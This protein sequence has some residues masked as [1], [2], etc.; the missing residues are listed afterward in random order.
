MSQ[1]SCNF[2]SSEPVL[3]MIQQIIHEVDDGMGQLTALGL[4][5][6]GCWVGR[7]TV[8]PCPHLQDELPSVAPVN[9]P[10]SAT[11]GGGPVFLLSCPQGWLSHPAPLG[12][13]LLCCL[14]GTANSLLSGAAGEGLGQPF[15]FYGPIASSS[16][17]VSGIDGQGIGGEGIFRPPM[18]RQDR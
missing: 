14:G 9:S 2:G 16:P 8:L 1:R 17:P 10:L 5:L 18:P 15:C 7:P 3:H 12:P 4:G 13:A 6:G 11:S